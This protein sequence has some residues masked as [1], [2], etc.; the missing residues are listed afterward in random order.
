MRAIVLLTC[1]L[2]L[3]LGSVAAMPPFA[4]GIPT[5]VVIDQVAMVPLIPFAEVVGAGIS[6]DLLTGAVTVTRG[7]ASF[8]CFPDRQTASA[9]RATIMLPCAPFIKDN[10]VYAPMH[11]VVSALKGSMESDSDVRNS[12]LRVRLPGSETVYKF[13]Q[14]ALENLDAFPQRLAQLFVAN[15]DGSGRKRL[16]YDLEGIA[17]PSLSPDGKTLLYARGGNVVLR[18]IDSHNEMIVYSS[19]LAQARCLKCQFMDDGKQIFFWISGYGEMFL[20]HIQCDGEGFARVPDGYAFDVR[21][22][23][24]QVAYTVEITLRAP[25]A[26]A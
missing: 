3:R 4:C 21:P 15:P 12:N 2:L 26:C 17:G 13:P 18:D 20:A 14:L 10:A 1:L 5:V 7:T 22:D 24:K 16:S 25:S 11:A 23:G 19:N 9:N 6:T 8:T